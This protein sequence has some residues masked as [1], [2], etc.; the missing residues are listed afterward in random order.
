MKV[1]KWLDDTCKGCGQPTKTV[2]AAWLVAVREK[3][4]VTQAKMAEECGVSRGYISLIEAGDR[5]CPPAVLD[6]YE[7]LAKAVS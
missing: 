4:K 7:S 2:N 3:A 6:V 1:R 5:V